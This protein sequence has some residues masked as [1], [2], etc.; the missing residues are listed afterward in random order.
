M[1]KR[2][3]LLDE[4]LEFLK[5]KGIEKD[6]HKGRGKKKGIWKCCKSFR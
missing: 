2:T 4:N 6:G 1:G 5:K 3:E